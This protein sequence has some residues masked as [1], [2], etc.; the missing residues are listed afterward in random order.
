M[1]PG[2]CRR[3]LLRWYD[4]NRRDLPWRRTRDPYAIWLSETMLQQTRVE[5]AIPYYERFLER[6]PDVE[7]LASAD[8]EDV[9]EEWSG[10]GYYTRARHLHQAARV[11]ADERGGNLPCDVEGLRSLPGVGRYTAG[12]VASIAFDRPAPVVDGNVARVLARVLAIRDDVG[13]ARVTAR[14]WEEA[15]RLARGRRPGDLN[16]ALMELG[17]RVCSPRNPDCE[18]CPLLGQCGA[19]AVDETDSI[20]SKRSRAPVPRVN[21]A[22]VLI[23][24]RDRFLAVRRPPGGLLGGLWEL[25]G[26]ELAA[27]ERPRTG[28]RR[29]MQRRL[30]LV[31]SDLEK[32]GVVEHLFS[33]RRLRLHVYRCGE[34]EGRL[35]LDGFTSHRWVSRSSL[36]RLAQGSVTRKAVAAALLPPPRSGRT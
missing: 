9:L 17:A 13:S 30:G 16:Q 12:A 28:I 4:A 5:T 31:A 6:F 23:R 14:L 36:H 20:P 24:R 18:V 26:V 35:R 15:A 11:I 19:R 10:L 33:H 7:A 2:R 3:A 21:A 8:L 25:P 27:K 29:A 1:D 34:P 32:A 22:A